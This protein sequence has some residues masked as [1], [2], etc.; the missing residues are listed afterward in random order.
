MPVS[1]ILQVQ[2]TVPV[3]AVGGGAIVSSHPIWIHAL[4]LLYFIRMITHWCLF[5][6]FTVSNEELRGRTASEQAQVIQWLSFAQHE[7]YPSSCVWVYPCLGIIQYNK[8]VCH[9][10]AITIVCD[11]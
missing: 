3:H 4:I 10:C 6:F 9:I 8:Q 7:I 2:K 1:Y 11:V 5:S